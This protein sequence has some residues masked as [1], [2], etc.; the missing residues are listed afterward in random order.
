MTRLALLLSVLV[1]GCASQPQCV[2]SLREQCGESVVPVPV[3]PPKSRRSVE[4]IAIW[5]NLTSDALIEA[6][7]RIAECDA[8][9]VDQAEKVR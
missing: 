6:N 4:N 5:G 7:R 9:K 1:S 8:P 2:A 3:P